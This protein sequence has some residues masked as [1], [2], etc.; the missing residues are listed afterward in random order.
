[1]SSITLTNLLASSPVD[2]VGVYLVAN[3]DAVEAGSV[4]AIGAVGANDATKVEGT[5]V[6]TVGITVVGAV[7][8][9]ACFTCI[10][11]SNSFSISFS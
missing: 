11:L 6:V 4:V 1:M 7:S 5:V 10:N 2:P 8:R 9:L 3:V